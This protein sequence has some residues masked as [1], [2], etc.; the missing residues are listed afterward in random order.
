MK[1][2][3][4]LVL[5]VMMVF[6]M[7]TVAF[8]ADSGLFGAGTSAATIDA[9]GVIGPGE[10]KTI[11]VT[12]DKAAAA[13]GT[14]ALDGTPGTAAPLFSAAV[15]K[16]SNGS[17]TAKLTLTVNKKI[18]LADMGSLDTKTLVY[19]DT[20][21]GGAISAT[22]T[23]DDTD[24]ILFTEVPT[25]YS[26]TGF[27]TTDWAPT[28]ASESMEE[29]DMES[30]LPLTAD[31]F[32]WEDK[33]DDAADL[34]IAKISDKAT[35]RSSQLGKVGVRKV[36]Q[37]GTNNTIRDVELRD[38][39]SDVRV[40][41]VQFYP[42][43]KDTDVELKL[44]LT[45]KGSTKDAPEYEYSFTVKNEEEIIEEGQNE[46]SS[47]GNI[48]LKADATVRNVE[49]QGDDEE[50]VFATKTVVKGQKYYFNVSTDLSDADQKIIADNPEVDSIYTVYQTNMANATIQFKD[51]DR[52]F[53]VYGADGKLLGTTKDTKLPLA[54]K[55][56][57]TTA[58]VD[59]GTD[60][61]EEPADEEPA[62]ETPAEPEAP[63]M[64]GGEVVDA[65]ATYNPNTGC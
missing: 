21:G 64:G 57:L 26:I 56:I 14:V 59:F 49:F 31:M 12:L 50:T 52:E 7:S 15:L 51:L 65:P 10:T 53:F 62:E 28:A 32:T 11:D 48:Y 23:F 3:L 27:A 39:K 5:A 45:F 17:T 4:S 36:Y 58:K 33:D 35:V 24:D 63:A 43:T 42:L 6:G 44:A 9:V 29:A 30:F 37:K 38:S 19:T 2:V 22:I 18:A 8:A 61:A 13:S 46:A 34:A 1:K 55:Y 60:E 25:G 54:G 16:L 47:Y 20:T 41:T 40:R